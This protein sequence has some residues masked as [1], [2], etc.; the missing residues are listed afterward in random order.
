LPTPSKKIKTQ[1]RKAEDEFNRWLEDLP[2]FHKIAE[3]TYAAQNKLTK[4][5][6]DVLTERI[7]S[8]SYGYVKFGE[9]YFTVPAEIRKKNALYF[10]TEL[11]KD[12]A[13][14]DIR[15]ADFEFPKGVCTECGKKIKVKKKGKSD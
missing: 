11:V 10:A 6:L 8:L 5:A 15:V 13:T 7:D 1:V 14:L 2:K 12:L 9:S 3:R 4:E